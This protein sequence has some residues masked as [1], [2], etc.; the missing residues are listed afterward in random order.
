MQ[1]KKDSQSEFVGRLRVKHCREGALGCFVHQPASRSKQ[2]YQRASG[3]L[4]EGT[5]A[6]ACGAG[7]KLKRYE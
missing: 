1:A 4:N 7:K 5:S 3:W 6:F 2:D